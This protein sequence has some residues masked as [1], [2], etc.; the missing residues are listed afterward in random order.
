MTISESAWQAA[1]DALTAADDVALACHVDPDGDAIGSMLALQRFLE[2]RGV[3]TIASWGTPDAFAGDELA[4][5]P[6]YAFLPGLDTLVVPDRFPARPSLMVAFDT[7]APERLGSLRASGEAA[8][9]LIV[10]DH[11]AS[12][13]EFGDVRLVDGSLAAT[14]VLVDELIT[15]MGGTLDRDTAI[16]LYTAL[17]TDTGR[18][19]Y[20]STTPAVLELAARLIS[21]DIDHAAISR[22]VWNTHS[23]GYLKLLAQVLERATLEPQASLLWTMVTQADLERF[24]V[25]WQ[26]TEGL[27]DVLRSVETARVAMIAKRQSDGAWKVSLRSRGDVDVGRVARD[28]GGGGHAFLAGL[29]A[30]DTIEELVA[31]V[32][33]AIA[34]HVRAG[35]PTRP[36]HTP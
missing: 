3:R 18:F 15:R 10:I 6:Q 30:D 36:A 17:V 20:A 27:I 25:A 14:A 28:L 31:R 22:Q 12:G 26:E 13:Q 34:D 9:T 35:A 33:A 24:G 1:V 2:G 16:C 8:D 7:G 5:P 19:Q 11:H 32:A 4:V 29:V 21:L 23:F